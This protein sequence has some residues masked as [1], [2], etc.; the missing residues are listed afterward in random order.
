MLFGRLMA[1]GTF[2]AQVTHANTSSQIVRRGKDLAVD[3]TQRRGW[4][5]A[6]VLS[7]HFVESSPYRLVA[8][9][10]G[11]TKTNLINLKLG[12]FVHPLDQTAV[13][14]INSDAEVLKLGGVS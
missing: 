7:D 5:D 12:S 6:V 4:D 14:S 3:T 2:G 11:T 9:Y 8:N 10:C 13:D 1:K